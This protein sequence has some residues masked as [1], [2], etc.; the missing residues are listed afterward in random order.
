MAPAGA[1]APMPRDAA[2]LHQRLVALA[3]PVRAEGER[4][5]LKNHYEHLGVAHRRPDGRW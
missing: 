3:D 1:G 2:A 5:Y 4:A